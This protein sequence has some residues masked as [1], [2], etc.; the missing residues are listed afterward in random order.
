MSDKTRLELDIE[1]H[2]RY[3]TPPGVKILV[4]LLVIIL[5]AGGAFIFKLH[6]EL[7]LKESE[8]AALKD[9]FRKEKTA[10][11]GQ[12]RQ[13]EEGQSPSSSDNN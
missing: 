4:V 13:F 8:I 9:D 12:I 5:C 10:L 3:I 6:N 2:E 7:T 1:H 11:L